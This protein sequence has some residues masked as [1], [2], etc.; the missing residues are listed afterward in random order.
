M[1]ERGVMKPVEN[2]A[3]DY[4][5]YRARKS[6]DATEFEDHVFDLLRQRGI[7]ATRYVSRKWQLKGECSAGIEVKFDEVSSRTGRLWIEVYEKSHPDNPRYVKSGIYRDDNSW[8][9][10]IGNYAVVFVFCKTILRELHKSGRYEEVENNTGT[11]VGFFLSLS[12]AERWAAKVLR[13]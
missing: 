8:L 1:G 3:E 11:S 5:T 6:D 13:A 2:V 4:A 10:A 7:T 9:Y 12:H